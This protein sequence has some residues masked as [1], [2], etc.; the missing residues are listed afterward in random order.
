VLLSG[1]LVVPFAMAGTIAWL[2]RGSLSG[3]VYL[4][5]VAGGFV[6]LGLV[7]FP[8]SDI[9]ATL[10]LRLLAPP[11]AAMGVM[12]L[13]GY[14]GRG[15][16]YLRI[17][18]TVL[19]L[20]SLLIGI[21]GTA[22]FIATSYL[23]RNPAETALIEKVR[24]LPPEAQILMKDTSQEFAAATGRAFFLA[25][26]FRDDAYLPATDRTQ[27]REFFTQMERHL[28]NAEARQVLDSID[29]LIVHNGRE[30]REWEQVGSAP[31]LNSD[32]FI[33]RQFNHLINGRLQRTTETDLL[34]Q[35][36][37]KYGTVE[38]EMQL[39]RKQLHLRATEPMDSGF[40]TSV[41]L[42]P[43]LYEATLEL[44]G[45]IRPGLSGG[46]HFSVHGQQRLIA[47]PAGDFPSTT[48]FRTLFKL[49]P[50]PGSVTLSLGFGGWSVGAGELNVTRLTLLH[51]QP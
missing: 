18:G 34:V 51:Y 45:K 20:Q 37:Q 26:T 23:P 29:Y 19:M 11:L 44:S 30:L 28:P 3:R 35:D 33:L 42:P 2:R 8:D 4:G 14:V 21:T 32:Y 17:F 27:A 7:H 49:A 1:G 36:W 15:Y 43:G 13:W 24:A 31:L 47:I 9:K 12:T 39:S 10:F 50:G 25:A 48:Q 46:A 22:Y 38:G 16:R 41:S 40:V 5:L 6:F